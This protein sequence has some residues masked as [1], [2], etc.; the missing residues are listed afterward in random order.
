MTR[1]LT[2]LA[3]CGTLA[4]LAGCGG[5]EKTIPRDEGSTLIRLLRDARDQAKDLP[6][7]CDGLLRTASRVQAEVQAL[8]RRVER[9]TRRT[10]SDGADNL[11]ALAEQ[12]CRDAE[13]E[14]ERTDTTDTTPTAPPTTP[15]PPPT[16]VEPEP[17]TTPTQPE[18]PTRPEP[19]EPDDD[20]GTP[21]GGT[22]PGGEGP[23]NGG[24]PPG[25]Q[26]KGGKKGGRR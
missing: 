2:A 5:D 14:R 15:T 17:P 12:E 24:V 22:P 8:P 1:L 19:E 26:K 16:R 20:G 6:D 11:A 3:A 25:Q 21:G 18:P 23:G 13:R 9:D 7:K 10:L 4:V